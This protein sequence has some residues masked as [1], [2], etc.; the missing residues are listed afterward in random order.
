MIRVAV[1]DDHVL[2]RE[3]IRKILRRQPDIQVIGEARGG[4]E[5]L[6]LLRN[7]EPDVLIL[8]I[9][10]PGRSGI[11]LLGD[12]KRLRPKLRV[13][14]LSMYA[15]AHYAVR[16]LKS[17]AV[18]Y[19]SK[20]SATE[21]VV[22]AIKRI[23]AGGSY[24]SPTVADTLVNNLIGPSQ[25]EGHERLTNRE[26]RILCM[27]GSGKAVKQIAADLGLS[28]N[29]IAT[30]RARILKKMNMRSTAALIRY[31]LEHDLVE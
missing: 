2:I 24:V 22:A 19:V 28:I 26:L 12:I 3:G 6:A 23:A 4:D 20:S 1:A 14:V 5:L 17:G 16:A 10:L 11:D 29:T 18:G 15:G 30:Y 13:L 7:A 25:A 31:A 21:E 8:D 9:S 27:I